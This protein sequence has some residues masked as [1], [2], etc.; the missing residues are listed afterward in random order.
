[1]PNAMTQKD[2][3]LLAL[4]SIFWGGAF[5]F[6]RHSVSV[7]EPFT[8]AF[9]RCALAVVVLS[10]AIWITKTPLLIDKTF[11]K[12][13]LFLGLFNN[14]LPFGLFFW[15]QQSIS[16]AFASILAASMPIF[17][18]LLA[19]FLTEHEKITKL[20]LTG[21]LSGFIGVSVLMGSSLKGQNLGQLLPILAC[22]GAALS[23]AYSII[24]GHAR[25]GKRYAPTTVAL[26]QVVASVLIAM[27]LVLLFEKPFQITSIPLSVIAAVF[28]LGTISTGFAYLIYF[29]LVQRV[30][31]TNV[32]LVTLL[33]PISATLLSA[34][35]LSELPTLWQGAGFALIGVGLLLIDGRYF[36]KFYKR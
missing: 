3:L 22:L 26:G 36:N 8:L 20:K 33:N 17:T 19:H 35:L 16:A 34:L 11:I 31:A 21:V 32:S 6:A 25:M 23:Y 29:K 18:V 2:Y 30:G 15:A 24:K 28:I 13:S 4:L 10:A 9:L 1:M 5:V 12:S 14:V 27:P 7:F